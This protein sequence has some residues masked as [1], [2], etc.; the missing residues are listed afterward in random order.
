M[1]ECQFLMPIPT[2]IMYLFYRQSSNVFYLI[3]YTFKAD[4]DGLIENHI[5]HNPK[6]FLFNNPAIGIID[7]N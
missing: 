1:D 3:R 7:S 4:R 6:E 2:M 5:Y